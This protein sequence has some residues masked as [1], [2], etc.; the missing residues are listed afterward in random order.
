M[1]LRINWTIA[2]TAI[3]VFALVHQV[4]TSMFDLNPN[5]LQLRIESISELASASQPKLAIQV[6]RQGIALSQPTLSVLELYNNG[7]RPIPASDFESKLEITAGTAVVSA[8][9][10]EEVDPVDLKPVVSVVAHRVVLEPLLLNPGDRVK[11]LVLT[12][13]GPPEFQT[14]ARISGIKKVKSVPMQ[15]R[16]TESERIKALLL[17]SALGPLS[18]VL[19]LSSVRKLGGGRGSVKATIISSGMLGA[20][21]S[22]PS[23]LQL[24]L[25]APP[26]WRVVVRWG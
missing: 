22:L 1:R 18:L 3:A 14:N 16:S 4:L 8:V 17:A 11:L 12:E 23:M 26:E 19:I 6:T 10:L 9:N 25:A 24:A 5:A 21:A 2:A 20:V 13:G 15:Q 7:G